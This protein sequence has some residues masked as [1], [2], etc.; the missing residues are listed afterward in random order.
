VAADLAKLPHSGEAKT[1]TAGL[2]ILLLSVLCISSQALFGQAKSEAQ[3]HAERGLQIMQAGDLPAAEAEF[4]Q[5]VKLSPRDPTYLSDLGV[6]LGMEQRL[7]D[8]D[9]YFEEAL[10]LEP[11]NV[12]I[13][14]NLAKNQ[15]RLG[16][17]ESARTNLLKVL[18]AQPGDGESTLIL[19]MVEENLRHFASA[20]RLLN[21]VP[22]LVMQ[23]PEAVAALAHSYY[24][25]KNPAGGRRTLRELFEANAPPEAL[26][27][28]GQTAL[29]AEDFTTAE[30]LF[31]AAGPGYPDRAKL[32]YYLA[33]CRYRSGKFR[34]CQETVLATLAAGPPTRELYTLL[35]WCYGR[36]DKIEEATKAFDQAVA[37]D[38]GN[39]TTYLDLGTLLLEH[40]QDELALALGRETVGK[41]P[42]SYRALMLRGMAEAD[43]GYLTDAVKSFGRVVELNPESPE[44]NYDLATIQSVAG[45]GSDALETL[46]GGIKKFPRDAP[47]YQAYAAL[48]VPQ[49]E[50]GD[51]AAETRAYEALHKALSLDPKLAQAHLL[52]GRLELKNNRVE[53]AVHELETA[54]KLDPNDAAVH[55]TLSRA[56][57]RLGASEKAAMELATYKKLAQAQLRGG[58]GRAPIA[59]RPW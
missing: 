48:E 13:R 57:A 9:R 33:F 40:R 5:A 56:Y 54:S 6:V 28:G 38:P 14:R 3:L 55:Q 19:G 22:A 32:G 27:L 53:S 46:Q 1:V 43:L 44:A 8:S 47:H 7:A 49:A 37:L 20:A 58:G 21:S 41:F 25:I 4:R 10:R 24:E 51:A 45:F 52:L 42:N 15:W 16:E 18:A 34:D 29:A 35:G 26:Y 36:Q 50:G 30:E 17:F 59:L 11:G 23:H 39:E 31:V 2:L 12:S